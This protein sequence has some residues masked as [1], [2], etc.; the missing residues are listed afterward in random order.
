MNNFI[1][2]MKPLFG[3]QEREELN[4]YLDTEG[5]FTEYKKTEEFEELIANFTGSK[6]CICV[7]NGTI[8]LTIAALALGIKNND[9]I[10]VPNYSMIA[11]P[12]SVKMIGAIPKFVDVEE[13]TLIIDF[14][15]L[16]RKISPKTKAIIMVSANGRE[17]KTNINDYI[18]LSND[19]GIP[20]IEDAAQSL[21]SFTKEGK[22]LG[23]L[24]LVGSFS[25]SAPKIISTG[26]GG[27]LITNNEDIAKRIRQLKDFGRAKGGIDIHDTIG[28]NFKF[29]ELQACVGIAQFKQLPDR[30]IRKKAIW[31]RYN[32]NLI[33]CNK[34]KL[35]F[36]DTNYCS[37]WFIDAL[38]ENREKLI[39]F[40]EINNIGTRRM[41]PPINKQKA[42][43]FDGEFPVSNNVGINGLWLPSM[44]QLKDS[45]IDYICEKI[46]NFYT[47][48]NS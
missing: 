19:Y 16:K 36:N 23:T 3:K 6:Y 43:N 13:D 46:I 12:N 48:E 24:G 47:Y 30:I 39:G 45:E 11:T 31:K 41:Y 20:I 40:L 28:Y 9:E 15:D 26:Q 29:T 34:I 27:A 7:N 14:N 42:Y 44:V 18:K 21:G 10:I 8:S 35:F 2:Q 4:A 33:N 5:Y 32:D 37:P 25:F 1:P 17:P 22:H 38:V